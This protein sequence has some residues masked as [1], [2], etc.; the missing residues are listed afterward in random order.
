MNVIFC[1]RLFE[2]LSSLLK[3]DWRSVRPHLLLPVLRGWQCDR[4]LGCVLLQ[5]GNTLVQQF[6][7]SH[8]PVYFDTLRLS[9][10]Q[11]RCNP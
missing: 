10:L 1:S 2:T 5:Y 4:Q 7:I 9:F 3:Y 6:H 11:R 8:K